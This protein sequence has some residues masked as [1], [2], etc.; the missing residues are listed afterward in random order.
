MS[1]FFVTTLQVFFCVALLCGLLWSRGP[2][3]AVRPLVWSSLGGLAAGLLCGLF[4]HGS[5]PAQLLLVCAEVLVSLLF[6]LSFWWVP[7]RVRYLLQGVLVLGAARHW[8][9]DPNLGG[10]TSTHVLN[11]DLLLNLTSLVL[12]FAVL[13]LAAVLCGMLV[14]RLRWLYWPLTLVVMVLIWLPL[15]G[16]VLLLLMKLQVVPLL[17]P[18]LSFVA[19]VTNNAELYNWAGA[20]VLLLLAVCWLPALS[21]RFR[22]VRLQQDPIAHRLARAQRRNAIRL[23]LTTIACAAVVVAGQLWWNLVA[24]QPPQL[25]QAQPVTLA[26]DGMVHLPV[27]QLR[28]GKLHR[29]V[30]VADD[31]K[32]VRFF[33][34]NRYPDK[35]RFGVVF[36][37]CL[38]CGDQGYVMEGNQVICVAC[39]VHIFIPSIGKA[40]GCNPVPID[41][42]RNDEKELTIPRDALAAGVNYFST[43]MTISV[44]DPVDKTTLTNTSA[45]YKYSW[46]GKTWFFAS[47]AN[48][49]R[50]RSAPEQ[51]APGLAKEE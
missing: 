15:S 34:I 20:G 32:A 10:L 14:S 42:W 5:Q 47:E 11:T 46:G 24:S 4:F 16:N 31:G 33:I 23:L 44:T 22:A 1:Y 17:K 26:S 50:F 28:D 8:G 19:R 7:H 27:A 37:A 13:S 38:L 21:R 35:L 25:S 43:V 51:F 3:P 40:G 29:F 12:A 41:N 30:W 48:Y 18:L 45:E 49:N 9:L 36:D 2:C 6:L 39:G